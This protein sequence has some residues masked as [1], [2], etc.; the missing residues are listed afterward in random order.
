ME[1]MSKRG[2][3]E[4]QSIERPAKQFASDRK[5]RGRYG[6]AGAQADRLAPPPPR[7]AQWQRRHHMNDDNPEG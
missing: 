4:H 6:A 5:A 7:A 3:R 1:G 2:P